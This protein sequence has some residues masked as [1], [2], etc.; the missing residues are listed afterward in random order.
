MTVYNRHE[1][2]L[3]YNRMSL[4][5]YFAAH[6]PIDW[7]VAMRFWGRGKAPYTDQDRAMFFAVWTM[8]RYEYADAMLKERTANER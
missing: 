3:A 1:E 4:R 5:D 2:A 8:L 7:D 6:A